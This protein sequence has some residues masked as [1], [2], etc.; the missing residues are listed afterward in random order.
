MITFE[1]ISVKFGDNVIYENFTYTFPVGINVIVGKSGCGKTT[2][3]NVAANLVE[4]TGKCDTRGELAIVF[5]QPC[6]APVS[7]RRN[8]DLVL[9]KRYD[10]KQVDKVLTLAQIVHKQDVNAQKLSGGEQQRVAIARAFVT[11]RPILLLDE[12]FEG[13]DYGTKKQ[14]QD[15]LCE[16]LQHDVQ[17]R[18]DKCVLLVTHD[19]DEALFLA[20]RIY[21]LHNKPCRLDLVETIDV[22][23]KA[24]DQFAEETLRLKAKLQQLLQE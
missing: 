3:L 1:N 2:L 24:R 12:P 22:P 7:V 16:M 10:K 14:L 17:S 9:P 11:D 13:L 5:Q 4:Y 23:Q 20:D 8:I 21:L 15:V 18:D 6:L 19:I